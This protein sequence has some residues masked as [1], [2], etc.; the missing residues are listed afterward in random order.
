MQSPTRGREGGK[1]ET[2]ILNYRQSGRGQSGNIS[3]LYILKPS[4]APADN[5]DIRIKV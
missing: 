1:A 3:E 4:R 5:H 2:L